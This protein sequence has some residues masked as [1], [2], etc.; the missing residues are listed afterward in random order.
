MITG[1]ISHIIRRPADQTIFLNEPNRLSESPLL[2]LNRGLN[3]AKILA[4]PPLANG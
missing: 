1:Q 3:L 4:T 2:S